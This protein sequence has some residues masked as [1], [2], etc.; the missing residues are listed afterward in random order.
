MRGKTKAARRDRPAAKYD[1]KYREKK[2]KL[3]RLA[4]ELDAAVAALERLPLCDLCAAAH[5]LGDRVGCTHLPAHKHLVLD[6]ELIRGQLR[7]LDH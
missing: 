3:R 7:Q 2:S 5:R 6:A 1:A 4:K